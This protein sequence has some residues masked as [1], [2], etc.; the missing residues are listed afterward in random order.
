MTTQNDQGIART[1]L[2]LSFLERFLRRPPVAG[3][4]TSLYLPSDLRMNQ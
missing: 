3:S 4:R 1:F 2:K